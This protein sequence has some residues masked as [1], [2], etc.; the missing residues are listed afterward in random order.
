MKY[1]DIYKNIAL[2]N[3]PLVSIGE[4]KLPIGSV[5]NLIREYI[6]L[7]PIQAIQNERSIDRFD[8]FNIVSNLISG[9]SF[10]SKWYYKY[11]AITASLCLMMPQAIGQDVK[12][13]DL[14]NLIFPY[15][16]LIE[17]Q[18]RIY[19][20]VA[21][22]LGYRFEVFSSMQKLSTSLPK[23]ID[24]NIDR[25]QHDKVSQFNVGAKTPHSIGQYIRLCSVGDRYTIAVEHSD[26]NNVI[27]LELRF[28]TPSDRHFSKGR[29]EISKI[30]I[31]SLDR[32]TG[33]IKR[34][35]IGSLFINSDRALRITLSLG[36]EEISRILDP[37][38][39][40]YFLS[41]LGFRRSRWD[42]SHNFLCTNIPENSPL[43]GIDVWNN[44]GYKILPVASA[45]KILE[46]RDNRALTEIPIIEK[47]GK[48]DPIVRY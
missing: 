42:I 8:V 2:K 25:I 21:E 22:D 4:Q 35:R 29:M 6:G 28:P 31:R 39:A 13:K 14:K 46:Y 23:P 17:D 47:L 26:R 38:I 12:L 27:Q 19:C 24:R 9:Q 37:E 20:G 5:V 3:V 34:S 33:E 1:L 36:L 7:D 11:P 15:S 48:N 45:L 16:R 18:N 44:L 40:G 32:A 10:L 41:L 30:F 43:K